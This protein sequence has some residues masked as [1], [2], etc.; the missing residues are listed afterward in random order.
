MSCSRASDELERHAGGHGQLQ[1][2]T[3]VGSCATMITVITCYDVRNAAGDAILVDSLATAARR[4]GVPL[5]RPRSARC[6]PT[7]GLQRARQCRSAVDGAPCACTPYQV[8]HGSYSA[9]LR[10][11]PICC[12]Y[13]HLAM[14]V[15]S[16][17][18]AYYMPATDS[19]DSAADY[20][21]DAIVAGNDCVHSPSACSLNR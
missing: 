5:P 10:S 12:R 21:L 2:H 18:A 16:C 9:P 11:L 3:R 4:A 15:D 19:A 8:L 6:V 20:L 14:H 1:R 17:S 13:F 7:V